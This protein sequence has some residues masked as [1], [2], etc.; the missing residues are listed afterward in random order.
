MYIDINTM[1]EAAQQEVVEAAAYHFG[2]KPDT[3]YI[4]DDGW[5]Y[6]GSSYV[7]K[8]VSYDGY[9]AT[10]RLDRNRDNIRTFTV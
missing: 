3:G 5:I 9:T 6:I 1:P 2:W 10:V 7:G 8:V 4:N